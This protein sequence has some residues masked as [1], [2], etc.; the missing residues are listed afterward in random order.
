[1]E[2]QFKDFAEALGWIVSRGFYDFVK[3]LQALIENSISWQGLTSLPKGGFVPL[4]LENQKG[5]EQE[6]QPQSP[7]GTKFLWLGRESK[8]I[9]G[10]TLKLGK[11][12][13]NFL[14]QVPEGRHFYWQ[15]HESPTPSQLKNQKPCKPSQTGLARPIIPIEPAFTGRS[16]T[17]G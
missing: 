9:V 8:P 11:F 5:F 12:I 6:F 16:N 3:V 10:K 14:P 13:K 4:G 15:G 7:G 17:T 1:L 2:L